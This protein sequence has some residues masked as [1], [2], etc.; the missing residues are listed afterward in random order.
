MIS[1]VLGKVEEIGVDLQVWSRPILPSFP[2]QEP[3]GLSRG[4]GACDA[5]PIIGVC[6]PCWH[7]SDGEVRMLAENLYNS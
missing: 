6:S 3:V 2:V 4:L 5:A 7:R 1:Y